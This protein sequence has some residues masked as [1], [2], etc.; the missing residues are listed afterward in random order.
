MSEFYDYGVAALDLANKLL[1]NVQLNISP[2]S[3]PPAT[4]NKIQL[5]ISTRLHFKLRPVTYVHLI[6]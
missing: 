3:F 5:Q 2:T 4:I 6:D 1:T